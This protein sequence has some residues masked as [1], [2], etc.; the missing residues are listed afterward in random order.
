MLPP[1]NSRA[2]FTPL[3]LTCA[4]SGTYSVG[5]RSEALSKVTAPRIQVELPGQ[6]VGVNAAERF[7]CPATLPDQAVEVYLL[8]AGGV[9][10][11]GGLVPLFDEFAALEPVY[12]SS[13][14]FFKPQQLK[15]GDDHEIA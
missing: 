15:Y 12:D 3:A 10:L 2:T 7:E 5:F 6:E 14:F 9:I 1:R 13:G 11:T 4:Q 8:D